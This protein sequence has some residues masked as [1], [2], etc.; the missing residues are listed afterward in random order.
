MHPVDRPATRRQVT[1]FTLGVLTIWVAAGSPVHDIAEDYLYSVHMVQHMLLSFVAP[2]LLVLGTP[3]WLLRA[4]LRPAW[5]LTA[6]RAITR[7]LPALV[8]FNVVVA[9]SHWTAVVDASLRSEPVHLAA[10]ATLFLSA[11]VMWMPVTSPLLELPRLAYP[12]QMLYL[13]IHS[14]LPTVPASF[15]TLGHHPLYRFYETVPRLWGLSAMTDQRIAGLI[16]KIA[17]GFLLWGVIAALFFKWYAR[18]QKEGVDVLEWQDVDRDL[19]RT[20]L[21]GDATD[22][23]R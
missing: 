19:R 2:P 16:M 18:E 22:V 4:L 5:L 1:L 17:G 11:I 23:R 9:L 12:G 10:H 3:A 6:V 20:K 8:L 7:P 14:L 15:L 21:R 13:F